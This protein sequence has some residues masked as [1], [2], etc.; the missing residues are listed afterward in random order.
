MT[1]YAIAIVDDIV[2][3]DL[4]LEWAKRI[5]PTLPSSVKQL[6]RGGTVDLP[7]LDGQDI[8]PSGRMAP[9]DGDPTLPK[10]IAIMEFPSYDDAMSWYSSKEFQKLKAFRG[11]AAHVRVLVIEGVPK[12]A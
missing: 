6:A 3:L 2:D 8:P 4:Y 5:V 12:T 9:V 7:S 1:A 11:D 10:R